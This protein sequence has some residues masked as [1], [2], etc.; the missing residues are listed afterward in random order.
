VADLIGALDGSRLVGVGADL[1]RFSDEVTEWI[2]SAAMSF[3]ADR[4]R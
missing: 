2:F 3:A 1:A 4:A